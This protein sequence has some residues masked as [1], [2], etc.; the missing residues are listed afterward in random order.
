MIGPKSDLTESFVCC[1]GH[2]MTVFSERDLVSEALLD[3]SKFLRNAGIGT[4]VVG[5]ASITGSLFVTGAIT[6]GLMS[7]G[8]ALAAIAG[9]F[10]LV[11]LIEYVRSRKVLNQDPEDDLIFI[12][13]MR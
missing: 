7:G 6:A 8:I 4:G 12:K 11:A 3:N 9:I 10:L 5:G 1:T 2:E 13:A